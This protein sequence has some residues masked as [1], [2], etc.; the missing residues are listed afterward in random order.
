MLVFNLSSK[1]CFQPVFPVAY[2]ES[3]EYI[4]ETI[5]YLVGDV[6]PKDPDLKVTLFSSFDTI[7]MDGTFSWRKIALVSLSL[8]THE[9]V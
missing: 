4:K 8:L 3:S 5:N 9:G 7:L 6:D 1:L 2:F